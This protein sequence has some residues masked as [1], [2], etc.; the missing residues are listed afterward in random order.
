[1]PLPAFLLPIISALGAGGTTATLGT[2]AAAS[3]T[4]TTT[5]GL[6]GLLGV[7]SKALPEVTSLLG[8]KGFQ[9]LARTGAESLWKSGQSAISD[10]L[11]KGAVRS[12]F[13]TGANLLKGK[14]FDASGLNTG[15]R[16]GATT[17]VNVSGTGDNSNILTAILNVLIEIRDGSQRKEMFYGK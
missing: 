3:S 15:P 14:A 11:P 13:N 8:E 10:L 6:S 2:A 5:T 7:A 17:N 1:M 16:E 9:T 12:L 4:A